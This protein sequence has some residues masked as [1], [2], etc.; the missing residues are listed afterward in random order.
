[1]TQ[2]PNTP[3]LRLLLLLAALTSACGSD[4]ATTTEGGQSE[5][6]TTTAGTGTTD[7]DESSGSTDGASGSAST[8]EAS[9]SGSTGE[10]QCEVPQDDALGR[11]SATITIENTTT[12]PRFISPYSSFVCN[13]AQ[14]EVL[15]D[16]EPV[17]WDHAGASPQSCTT[18]FYGC[19]DGGAQGLIINPGQTA[20]ISWNGGYWENTP[21]SEA[22]GRE[23]CEAEPNWEEEDGVPAQCQVRR[24]MQDAPYTVR[25]NVL[26]TCPLEPEDCSC[27][28]DVCEVF[29][30]EPSAGDYTVEA[31]ATF[32]AGATIVLE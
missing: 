18:C 7:G 22:C 29:F 17:L 19:S 13:Y 16:G 21:L 32:P 20:E 26:D 9:G 3:S 31:A 2:R 4:P 27:D 24:S 28:D 23:A 10:A 1:M 12:E 6:S 15:L 14:A 8:G 30:Y 5:T 25:V 11:S